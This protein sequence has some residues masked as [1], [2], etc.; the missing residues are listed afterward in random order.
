M[1]TKTFTE[2]EV[3]EILKKVKYPGYSRDIVSFGMVK[4]ILFEDHKVTVQL[5]MQDVPDQVADEIKQSA[6]EVLLAET[7]FERVHVDAE[8]ISTNKRESGE[9]APA[10]EKLMNPQ[11]LAGV[12]K[13]IAVS[14]GKGGV[15]KSTVAV[16]LAVMAAK[17]GQRVGIMD[18]D[19]H[20]PSLSTLL[21][22]DTKPDADEK[23]LY[24]FQKYNI[25]SMSI[26]FIIEPG[27]PL[28]WRGPMLNKALE[29]II[30]GT[31]WGELDMLFIDLPP[32]TGDVQIS[33]TQKYKIDGAIVVTT[34]Q[35]VALDDVHRGAVMF[36]H[37]NVPVLGVVEN[38]SYYRCP[39]CDDLSHPFG[40]GGGLREAEKLGLPLLGSIPMDPKILELADKGQPIVDAEPD[41]ESAKSY[42]ALYQNVLKQLEER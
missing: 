24:P 17:Q 23:G 20:G 12:D 39:H 2:S 22:I 11:P 7:D 31:H 42:F 21:G 35:N 16:N 27:Q 1:E 41:S 19:I 28:I 38:M 14:S 9:E 6:Q 33:L 4:A 30:E 13:I 10:S 26:G 36:Q 32:G 40:K 37:T 8:I 25:K 15:G 3:T 29:Q 18:A 5:Q 34:P